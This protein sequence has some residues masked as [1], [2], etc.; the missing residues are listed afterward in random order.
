MLYL[1]GVNCKKQDYY[2]LGEPL[3]LLSITSNTTAIREIIEQYPD[4][5]QLS[6]GYCQLS[7]GTEGLGSAYQVGSIVHLDHHRSILWRQFFLLSL[8]F[9]HTSSSLLKC[10]NYLHVRKTS[11]RFLLFFFESKLQ[12]TTLFNP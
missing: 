12:F 9:S 10:L 6:F 1:Y 5:F 3:S 7:K 8:G 11:E 2:L 4:L